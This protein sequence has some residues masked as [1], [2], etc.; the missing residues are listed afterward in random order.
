MHANMNMLPCVRSC[1]PCDSYYK[2]EFVLDG[3]ETASE[4]LLNGRLEH[5]KVCNILSFSDYY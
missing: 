4:R 2:K 1:T 5:G 3:R